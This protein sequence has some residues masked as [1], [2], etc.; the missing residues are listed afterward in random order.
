MKAMQPF[1]SVQD[2]CR[3][4]RNG[5]DAVES[6]HGVTSRRPATETNTVRIPE[7]CVLTHP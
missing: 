7:A 2:L 3:S 6:F 4:R 1:V 5:E